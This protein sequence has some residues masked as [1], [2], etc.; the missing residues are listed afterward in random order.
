MILYEKHAMP[1]D[2]SGLLTRTLLAS[3]EEETLYAGDL[4]AD[5]TSDFTRQIVKP[6]N[7]FDCYG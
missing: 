7:E 5:I 2:T 3:Q 4:F 1:V 6:K